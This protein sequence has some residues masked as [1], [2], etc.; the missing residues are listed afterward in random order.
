MEE[1][2]KIVATKGEKAIYD[3]IRVLLPDG[4]EIPN[5]FR[6]EWVADSFDGIP[7][8]KVYVY[9]TE[10]DV[11]TKARVISVCPMC[12]KEIEETSCVPIVTETGEKTYAANSN[13]RD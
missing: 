10:L 4:S 9:T 2:V 12:K 1:T 7:E 11:T 13:C 8:A 5:V 3:N 6:I